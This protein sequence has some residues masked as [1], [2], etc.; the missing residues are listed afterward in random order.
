MLSWSVWANTAQRNYLH[1]VGPWLTD[2][3]YEENNLYNFV[4]TML[5]QHCIG[6]SYAPCC[7]HT[8]E[9]ENIAQ[10]NYLCNIGTERR[11][12]L[13]QENKLRNVVLVCLGQ[14]CTNK[15]PAQCRQ[16]LPTVHSLV[17]VFQIRLRQLCTRKLLMQSWPRAHRYTFTEKPAVSNI[18][19]TKQSWLFLFNVGSRV[20]L[21]L[22]GQQWA[23]ANIDRN[24]I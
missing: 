22:A 6:I 4:S 9:Q 24:I 17:N 3:F 10:E 21:R 18:S 11:D 2:N 14:H 13:L 12:M 16:C 20:H 5:G 19:F 1:S 15:L 23:G 7:P 8:S